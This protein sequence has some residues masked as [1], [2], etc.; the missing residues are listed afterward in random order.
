[1]PF[2]A[3]IAIVLVMDPPVYILNAIKQQVLTVRQANLK[4]L[5]QET[6]SAI[7][8]DVRFVLLAAK[9]VTAT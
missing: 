5:V 1:M 6:R 4:A 7:T 2:N 3:K 9:L 8:K